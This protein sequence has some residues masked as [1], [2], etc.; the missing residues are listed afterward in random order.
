LLTATGLDEK[1]ARLTIASA[2]KTATGA[3]EKP[4][5]H[6][7]NMDDILATSAKLAANSNHAKPSDDST[8]A[9]LATDE[10]KSLAIPYAD[11]QSPIPLQR[12]LDKSPQFPIH[13]LGILLS[14]AA[15]TAL[16]SLW[17]GGPIS[18]SRA[19]DGTTKLYDR[20]LSIHLMVQPKLA[21]EL[22]LSNENMQDQGF[23]ARFLVCY[24]ESTIG[25]RTYKESDP[26]T[27]SRLGQY[28][29][30]MTELLGM[31]QYNENG[32]LQIKTLGITSSAKALWIDFYN[33]VESGMT[34]G[35]EYAEIRGFAN[36][37]T[38]HAARL[39]GII[40]VTS[41]PRTIVVN[42]QY[43]Q[44]GIELVYFYLAEALR[45]VDA[46][47]NPELEKAMRLLSW[48]HGPTAAR[49]FKDGYINHTQIY[50][51]GLRFARTPKDALKYMMIL[52]RH[53]YVSLV[54]KGRSKLW[55]LSD[56]AVT[57]VSQKTP[58]ANLADLA[59]VVDYQEFHVA[60]EKANLPKVSQPR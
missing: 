37:A 22:M 12:D 24:P 54:T 36:K 56:K 31:Y 26:F 44:W 34:S 52:E 20:R 21:M 41:D 45:L 38:E 5:S 39:A 51:R 42:E 7:N 4:N 15:L 48:L 33:R 6:I 19:Q 8:L 3:R 27:E 23:L 32:E 59:K 40:A 58:V 57:K 60:E 30:R 29:Q 28:W 18:R 10:K 16:S 17:C 43:M 14:N 55:K 50:M 53:G 1:E 49:H 11:S 35:G 2:F 9:T 47:P 13:A 46:K 25:F